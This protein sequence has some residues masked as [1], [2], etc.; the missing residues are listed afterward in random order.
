MRSQLKEPRRGAAGC[1]V[2]GVVMGGTVVGGGGTLGV[3]LPQ[4]TK[5]ADS[6]MAAAR[7]V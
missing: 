5:A 4:E 6:M 3:E 1:V 7:R 2:G